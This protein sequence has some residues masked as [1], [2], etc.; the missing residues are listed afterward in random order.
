VAK[1]KSNLNCDVYSRFSGQVLLQNI[2][3]TAQ[4]PKYLGCF[5]ENPN[6]RMNDMLI[7]H[8][9]SVVYV[10]PP[11]FADFVLFSASQNA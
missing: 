7:K 2:A 4:I 8:W 3:K 1:F 6:G 11:Y 9:M 10:P 5:D